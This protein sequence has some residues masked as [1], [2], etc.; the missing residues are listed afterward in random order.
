M[1]GTPRDPLA[2]KHRDPSQAGAWAG[3]DT[4]AWE[5]LARQHPAVWWRPSPARGL[6]CQATSASPTSLM[7]LV[8]QRPGTEPR[9]AIQPRQVGKVTEAGP[10]GLC[11][12]LLFG[13]FRFGQQNMPAFPPFTFPFTE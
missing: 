8:G 10:S 13:T 1:P 3:F 7:A 12:C 11:K 9:G 5:V 6:T 2:E 4:L